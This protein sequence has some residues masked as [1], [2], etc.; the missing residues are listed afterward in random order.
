MAAVRVMGGETESFAT[1]AFLADAFEF[2][3]VLLLGHEFAR[4]GVAFGF[5]AEEAV[6]ELAALAH[7]PV[8]MVVASRFVGCHGISSKNR[9]RA[10]QA[11]GARRHALFVSRP[12]LKAGMGTRTFGSVAQPFVGLSSNIG[13]SIARRVFARQGQ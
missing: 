3:A 9:Q 7:R 8:T 10:N 1:L 4:G 13:E 12:H 11:L 2:A 5:F 6:L